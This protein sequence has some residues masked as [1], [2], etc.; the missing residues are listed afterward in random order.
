MP[1]DIDRVQDA[2]GKGKKGK[3]KAAKGKGK[4]GKVDQKG[5]EGNQKGKREGYTCG[6]PGHLA[7]DC[8]G[9]NF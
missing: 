2:K 9:N 1:M 6:K 5:K 7:K 8:G 4:K 3:G